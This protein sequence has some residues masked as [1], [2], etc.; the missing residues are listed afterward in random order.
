MKEALSKSFLNACL[1]G[2]LKTDVFFRDWFLVNGSSY[3]FLFRKSARITNLQFA[4]FFSLL[5]MNLKDKASGS[6]LTDPQFITSQDF[7]VALSQMCQ[8]FSGFGAEEIRCVTELFSDMLGRQIVC[9]GF[10]CSYIVYVPPHL[11]LDILNM[12]ASSGYIHSCGHLVFARNINKVSEDFIKSRLEA[13]L[14]RYPVQTDSKVLFTVYTH[15]DFSK[16]DRAMS[17]DLRY[18][19]DGV[20]IHI[21]KAFV[22][23]TSLINALSNIR[24]R[25]E[26]EIEVSEAGFYK[27]SRRDYTEAH[28]D[29]EPRTLWLICDAGLGPGSKYPNDEKYYVCYDQLYINENPFYLFDEDKPA[30][31]SHTTIPH[32]MAGALVNISRPWWNSNRRT[33]IVD[34]FGGSGTVFFEAIKFQEVGA[35]SFDLSPISSQLL[36]DNLRLFTAT[37]D[38]LEELLNHIGSLIRDGRL[39]TSEPH[40]AKTQ[41]PNETIEGY[42]WATGLLGKLHCKRRETNYDFSPDDVANL[43]QKSFLT[44]VI[45]YL[46]LKAA[47]RG[48][49]EIQR[50]NSDWQA[51][52][53][54]QHANLIER[55]ELL[56]DVRR[57]DIDSKLETHD[58]LTFA[59]SYSRSCRPAL[60]APQKATDGNW[61]MDW[62]KRDVLELKP[63]SCDVIITDPPYGFNT[64]QDH[65]E[66][67][68]LFQNA[69]PSMLRAIRSGGQLIICCPDH[70]YSGR[71]LPFY[72][73]PRFLVHQVLGIARQ[74]GKEIL[75]PS[76]SLPAEVRNVRP[77]Y[78]WE[79]ERA[80]RRRILHFWMRDITSI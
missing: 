25:F 52:F 72:T 9:N 46:V 35:Q 37:K 65:L 39:V 12:C 34:P 60:H 69:V 20:K 64:D 38:E 45:F 55:L 56:I 5:Q 27:K 8:E 74:C 49:P 16:F 42:E 44:R 75:Q 63:N 30:W 62:A 29:A 50:Q 26:D 68:T 58:V 31:A 33:E 57:R 53:L 1:D 67:A 78:Y 77:P 23:R 2:E 21:N 61:A 70:S 15:E 51:L 19:L 7:K 43:C 54:D 10:H 71:T 11:E 3:V 17:S 28:P 24:D 13:H 6:P 4:E 73:D 79:S 32:T 40:F 41:P 18:G 48:S 36:R 22:G 59:G 66:L 47:I 76:Y 14:K 80:L